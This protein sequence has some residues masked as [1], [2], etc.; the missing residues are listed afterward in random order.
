MRPFL[1]L[2]NC[3]DPKRTEQFLL[4]QDDVV[5][6]SVWFD[7]GELNAYVTVSPES[8]VSPELLR[9]ACAAHIGE[10]HT[11]HHLTLVASRR[12]VA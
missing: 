5:D 7:S 11:P 8:R 9:G 6:A 10:N 1:M 2:V 4:S 3:V 12:R